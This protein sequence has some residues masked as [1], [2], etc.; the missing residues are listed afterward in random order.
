MNKAFKV[1]IIISV[2]VLVLA[3]SGS[4][5]YYFAFAKPSIE[6]EKLELEEEK[7]KQEEEKI[8]QE[9]DKQNQEAMEKILKRASLNDCLDSAFKE[10]ERRFEA[11]NKQYHESWDA[12]CKELNLSPGSDLPGNIAE[13]IQNHYE[14]EIERTEEAYENAKNDCF[15][16][17][18]E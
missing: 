7:I 13:P 2:V 12:A 16:K 3:I 9:E 17:Y 4:M 1:F 5:I 18:G 8:K 6:R 15:K 14:H 10:Y 11:C